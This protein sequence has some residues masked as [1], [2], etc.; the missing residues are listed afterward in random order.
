MA[1]FAN[2]F[3]RSTSELPVMYHSFR[4][5]SKQFGTL[6]IWYLIYIYK[7]VL[8]LL[9]DIDE[10]SNLTGS[11]LKNNLIRRKKSSQ[12]HSPTMQLSNQ[13]SSNAQPSELDSDQHLFVS[14]AIYKITL[15]AGAALSDCI[16]CKI[17]AYCKCQLKRVCY[18]YYYQ[19]C[20]KVMSYCVRTM[21]IIVN[22]YLCPY[23]VVPIIL[24]LLTV[25]Q[26]P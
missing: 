24:Q 25:E 15:P 8:L 9:K 3:G 18:C 12:F 14:W 7:I 2:L 4:R 17:L 21:Q 20:L 26:V 1:Q 11:P 13:L 16:I 6:Y 10:P 5:H 22:Y 19:L 23:C